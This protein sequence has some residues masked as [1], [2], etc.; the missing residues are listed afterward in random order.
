MIRLEDSFVGLSKELF[1][2][3]IEESSVEVVFKS[4][5]GI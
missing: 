3:L 2:K 5:V 4:S 1:K